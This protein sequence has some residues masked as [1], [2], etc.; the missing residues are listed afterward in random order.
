VHTRIIYAE[1]T[2]DEVIAKEGM[3]YKDETRHVIFKGEI[4]LNSAAFASQAK[5]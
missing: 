5:P 1:H 2:L 4:E 3:I